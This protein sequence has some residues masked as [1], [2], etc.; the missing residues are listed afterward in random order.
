MNSRDAILQRIRAEL[1]KVGAA[2]RAGATANAGATGGGVPACGSASA[3][4][5]PVPEVWPRETSEPA[6]L[7]LRFG[8]ELREVHGELIRSPSMQEARQ[9]LVEL[10]DASE[11]LSIGAADTLLTRQVA[12]AVDP[13]RVAWTYSGWPPTEIAKLPAGLVAAEWLLADTGTCVVACRTAEER[14]MCYLPPACVVVARVDQLAEHM[15]AAWEEIARQT[16]DPQ[17]R[18]EFVLVTGPSRT[19]DIEKI[20][21][22]GVHG[23][24][25]LI[26]I[27]VG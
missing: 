4:L 22:L 21:I 1:A 17:R 24:K 25:R 12:S 2:A 5:P 16:A 13:A 8:N 9:T 10:L 3:P 6:A 15:P 11:W 14:L 20:L 18:G 27:L 26:V 23:P 19:A 7:A